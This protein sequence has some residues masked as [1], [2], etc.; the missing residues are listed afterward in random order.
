M[1]NYLMTYT[2][3]VIPPPKNRLKQRYLSRQSNLSTAKPLG[4][5]MGASVIISAK[6]I[7]DANH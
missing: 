3:E 4:G 5:I 7:Q 2:F 1:P 6:G